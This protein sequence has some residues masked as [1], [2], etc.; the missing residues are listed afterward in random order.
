MRIG[1]CAYSRDRSVDPVGLASIPVI[2]KLGYDYVELT[3]S[4]LASLSEQGFQEVLDTLA[5]SGI[6]C[7]V[8]H[9]FFPSSLRL[10]G[11]DVDAGKIRDY[12]EK[13]LPRARKA[14]AGILVLGSP[15]AR[16]IPEGFSKAKAYEQLKELCVMMEPYAAKEDMIVAIEPLNYGESNIINTVA[17]GYQLVRDAGQPHIKLLADYFHWVRNGE[18][19]EI[20][21]EAAPVLVHTHFAE[22]ENRAFP[23]TDKEIYRSFVRELQSAGYDARI[24]MEAHVQTDFEAEAGAA[25][26]LFRENYL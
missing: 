6:S 22:N 8:C 12:L 11:P 5:E 4:G 24:S 3:L 14:G 17:E 19:L 9:G 21:K 25:L 20:L 26:N 7:E 23:C 10:T 1:C 16:N 13:A 15:G 18:P 2:Q